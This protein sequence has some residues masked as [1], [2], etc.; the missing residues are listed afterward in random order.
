[1]SDGNTGT[2]LIELVQLSC[3]HFVRRPAWWQDE[4]V[5]LA[6]VAGLPHRFFVRVRQGPL[7]V[8]RTVAVPVWLC[9]R[10]EREISEE[11][12]EG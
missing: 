10:C 8:P 5:T 7:D 3:G 4:P 6:S 2:D 1:M 9:P 12:E 11:S